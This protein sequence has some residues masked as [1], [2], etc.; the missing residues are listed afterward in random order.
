MINET[1]TFD[2]TFPFA[3]N[4]SKA[5]GFRMHY[6][7]EG[8]GA[9]ILCLHG[10]PT[11]G[12]LYRRLIPPL[13]SENRVVVPDLMGFGKSETPQDRDYS[14]RE[15]VSNLE[16]LLDEL[17]LSRITMILHDW[18]GLVGGA[19]ALLHPERVERFVLI[20]TMI[21]A[22]VEGT[23]DLPAKVL[24]SSPWF[25][26]A[27]DPEG[28]QEAVL[29]QLDRTVLSVMQF[30]GLENLSVVNPSWLRAYSAPF[31][32]PGA[33]RGAIAFPQEAVTGGT[34]Q[35]AA[36]LSSGVPAIRTKPA[37]LIEAMCDRGLPPEVA[38]R[39]FKALFPG[40][41]VLRLGQVGHFAQEDAPE[42]LLALIHL[43]LRALEDDGGA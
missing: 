26:W 30:I 13:A 38:I 31:E 4:F 5:P 21:P 14:L 12:Y 28:T 37:M 20:N 35:Y 27:T 17:E 10:Q 11:W 8:E 22:P 42:T 18:G 23:E 9:P 36:E 2:G 7:D 25:R 40:A 1:D 3:P 24:D 43:F 6:V 39:W 19:Y 29:A 15:H 41:P 33:C 34:L 32:G 16:A